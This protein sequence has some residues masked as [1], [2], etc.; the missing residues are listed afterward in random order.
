MRLSECS[1]HR[2]G[3]GTLLALASSLRRPQPAPTSGTPETTV[4]PR[5]HQGRGH[6][7]HGGLRRAQQGTGKSCDIT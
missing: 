3:C 1:D 7:R 4:R 2:G 5:R 6:H